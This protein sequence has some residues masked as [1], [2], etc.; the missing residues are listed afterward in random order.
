MG[1]RNLKDRIANSPEVETSISLADPR[2]VEEVEA[3]EGYLRDG[4]ADHLRQL[5]ELWLIAGSQVGDVTYV[6]GSTRGEQSGLR[7]AGIVELVR[8]T[9]DS[10]GITVIQVDHATCRRMGAEI[11]G[12]LSSNSNSAIDTISLGWLSKAL[13]P[14]S[15]ARQAGP[16]A[17]Q[18]IAAGNAVDLLDG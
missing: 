4:L 18:E 2:D 8:H 9:D 14:A 15:G 3:G 17:Y 11:R 13:D 5:A 7:R 1:P 10:I 12:R 16:A 6:V